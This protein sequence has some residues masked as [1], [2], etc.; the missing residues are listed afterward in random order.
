MVLDKMISL[1]YERR[2]V[3][4][5]VCCWIRTLFS[6]SQRKETD[7]QTSPVFNSIWAKDVVFFIDGPISGANRNVILSPKWMKALLEGQSCF[8][9][10][11]STD[12]V[13][14][15]KRDFY[16]QF[17]ILQSTMAHGSRQFVSFICSWP[18]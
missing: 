10:P 17:A 6:S 3:L 18:V 7:G 14:R 9:E 12:F 5:R 2:K 1:Q 11:R 4:N 16:I 8:I 15:L 13:F